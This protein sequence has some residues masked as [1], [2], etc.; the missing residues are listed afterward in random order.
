LAN[1]LQEIDALKNIIAG[2]PHQFWNNLFY[3]VYATLFASIRSTVSQQW[4]M[5]TVS[6]FIYFAYTKRHFDYWRHILELFK[7]SINLAKEEIER[8]GLISA[9]KHLWNVNQLGLVFS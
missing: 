3:F 8:I 6:S 4:S 1:N 2:Q 9:L 7:S 5:V